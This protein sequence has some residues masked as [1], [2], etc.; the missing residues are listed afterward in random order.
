MS[1]EIGNLT[2]STYQGLRSHCCHLP[3]RRWKLREIDD[4]ANIKRR[5]RGRGS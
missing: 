4:C 5:E 3:E 1:F 2:P